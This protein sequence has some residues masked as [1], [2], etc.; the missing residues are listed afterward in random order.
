MVGLP[1]SPVT[2]SER[3]KYPILG[4]HPTALTRNKASYS[5]IF[6]K[7][8]DMAKHLFLVEVTALAY[9]SIP[10]MLLYQSVVDSPT[11]YHPAQL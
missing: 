1:N 8:Q 2:P 10:T 11:L 3:D 4:V 7:T 9:L 5:P 6:P